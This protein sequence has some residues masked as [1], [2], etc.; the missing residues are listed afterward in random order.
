MGLA[1]VKQLSVP[2]VGTMVD[3]DVF[4]A[5]SPSAVNNADCD[6]DHNLGSVGFLMSDETKVTELP[7]C[8]ASVNIML[9][10]STRTEHY[11]ETKQVHTFVCFM[12]PSSLC[13]VPC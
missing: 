10:F 1:E 9:R 4:K 5:A 7:L 2:A 11:M 6:A 3:Y 12:L 13:L 8:L